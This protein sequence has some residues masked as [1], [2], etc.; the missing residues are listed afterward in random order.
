MNL[1][2]SSGLKAIST[3]CEPIRQ[4]WETFFLMISGKKGVLVMLFD[5][6]GQEE[7]ET[8]ECTTLRMWGK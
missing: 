5:S 7:R 1:E 3:Q 8:Q 4:G 2:V 6:R